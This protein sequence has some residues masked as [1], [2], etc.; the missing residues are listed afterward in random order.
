VG[1]RSTEDGARVAVWDLPIRL[2]H[3]TLVLLIAAAWWTAEEELHEWHA[4]VGL[5]IL[6]L[7]VFRLVWGVIGS[8]TAR[9]ASFVKGPRGIADYL[10]GRSGNVLG[11]NPLGALSV[12]ALLAVVAAEVGLGLFASDEDGLLSGPLAH[13]ISDDAAEEVTEL[14][15][16]LFDWLLILIGVHVAAILFYLAVKRDNLIAPMVH[17]RRTAPPG[18]VPNDSAPAWRF[19]VAAAI[20]VAIVWIVGS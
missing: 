7:I 11:H 10:R 15:A 5:F 1:P 17:G 9:F 13:W 14:H 19:A 16:D 20:A 6:G 12:L 2:F 4:R 18:T 8:S 3:W